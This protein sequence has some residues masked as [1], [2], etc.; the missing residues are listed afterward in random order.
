MP[1]K[2]SGEIK[3][4]I[5][6]N[7]QKNG[8]IYVYERQ[9]IYDP[10]KKQTVILKSKLLH[11]IPKDSD[12]PVP[13]RPKRTA[14]DKVA[15]SNVTLVAT[16]KRVRMMDIVEHIGAASGID[17]GVYGSTDIGTAQKT[18]SLARY[19]LASNGQSLPG[20]LTWQFNHPL[21]YTT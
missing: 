3:T 2:P 10:T 14:D 20:I 5:V 1:A 15:N 4:R 18:L 16:R 7:P 9:M 17:S 8:D 12:I 21:P 6:R 13:T 11:K 19:L